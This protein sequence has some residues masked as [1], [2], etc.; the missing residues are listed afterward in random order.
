[1]KYKKI[2]LSIAT[3]IIITTTAYAS[4]VYASVST[5][6]AEEVIQS[7]YDDVNTK[8]VDKI[9]ESLDGEYGESA[10]KIY[11]DEENVSNCVGIFNISNAEVLSIEKASLSD[12]S[13]LD[14]T[15]YGAEM[16]KVYK[17]NVIITKYQSDEEFLDGMNEL[18]FV[19]NSENK[20]IGCQTLDNMPDIPKTEVIENA[21]SLLSYDTPVNKPTSNPS[22][23]RVYRTSTGAIQ[24]VGFKEYC[25]VVNTCEVGYS[26]WD[27]AALRACAMAIKNYGIARVKRHKYAGLGYD[28]KDNTND[29]VYNPSK[30][31]VTKCDNAVDFIW[32]YYLVDAN[33]KLF[34]GFH[35]ANKNVNSYA[36]KHKGILSQ[37]KAQSLATAN[38]YSWREILKYFYTREKG[39]GYYNSEVAVGSVSIVQ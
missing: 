22:T 29:Q 11:T 20:I 15:D 31:R 6:T 34:P 7:Y 12:V 24:R 14:I 28:I 3:G 32:D 21:F 38:D 37:E 8:D 27:K 25:K 9:L 16:D 19:L 4:N 1:M 36:A 35:V 30:A 10:R 26:S 39:T 2:V 18:Y 23:I 5:Q 17:A 33:S 13:A